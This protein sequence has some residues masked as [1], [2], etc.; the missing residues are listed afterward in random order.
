[1]NE[2]TRCGPGIK[3][4][5]IPKYLWG[6]GIGLSHAFKETYLYINF[7]KWTINIGWIYKE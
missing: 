4:T 6:F 3:V 5:K 7:V 2:K 1:M